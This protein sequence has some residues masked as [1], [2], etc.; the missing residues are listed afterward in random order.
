MN[1]KSVLAAIACVALA[2]CMTAEKYVSTDRLDL[3]ERPDA[4]SKCIATLAYGDAVS[5]QDGWRVAPSFEGD[6]S[7]FPEDL[8]PAWYRVSARGQIGYVPAKALV[9]KRTIDEQDPTAVIPCTDGMKASRNNF[10]KARPLEGV[11][12]RGA[13]GD[14][15]VFSDPNYRIVADAITSRGEVKPEAL[16]RFATEGQLQAET[17]VPVRFDTPKS[18]AMPGKEQMLAVAGAG[19]S[20]AGI[21]TDGQKLAREGAGIVADACFS[22]AGPFQEFQVGVAVASCVLPGYRLAKA[23]DPRAAYVNTVAHSLLVASNDPEPYDGLT[24]TLVE[25]NEVNAFAVPGGFLVVTTGMLDF[26]KDEDELAAIIGHEIGHLELRHGMKSVN[27]EKLLNLFGVLKQAG[28][29]AAGDILKID[30]PGVGTVEKMID[31]AILEMQNRIRNGYSKDIESQADWRS[32]QL[33]AKLGYD[34]KALYEVLER[35]KSVNGSYGGAGYP[36]ERGADVL[37]YI[38][39]F[40]YAGKPVQ[41]RS[42]RQCRYRKS[43]GK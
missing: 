16:A 24:V 20:A 26:L 7:L 15:K 37:K 13:A 14:N 1:D 22:E 36:D 41:G 9:E 11:A 29:G 23:T 38:G 27:T 30:I 5:V 19:M 33:C 32:L 8:I 2:G 40:G 31:N 6:K 25:T 10:S 18:F 43:V 12:M 28:N 21:G 3:R 17:I 34:T 4:A 39:Q 42:V 35:F